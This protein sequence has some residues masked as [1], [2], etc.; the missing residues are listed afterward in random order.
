M[1][2]IWVTIT[3]ILLYRAFDIYYTVGYLYI[4]YILNMAARVT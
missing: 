3:S 1:S 2:K 4:V